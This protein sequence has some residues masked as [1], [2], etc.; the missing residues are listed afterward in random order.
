MN[1]IKLFRADFGSDLA[2]HDKYSFQ[3][4]LTGYLTMARPLFLILTPINAAS[5]AVLSI[6]GLPGWD[7]CLAGFFTGALAAARGNI[8]NRYA[9]RERDKTMWPRRAIPG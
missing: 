8:F 3:E 7:L 4:R 6:R 2:V 1:I 9:D 5:A